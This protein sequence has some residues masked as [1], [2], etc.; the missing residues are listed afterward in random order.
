MCIRDRFTFDV[1][2][3]NSHVTLTDAAAPYVTTP[4]LQAGQYTIDEINM[5]TGWSLANVSCVKQTS[6]PLTN[7]PVDH[8]ATITVADGDAWVCTFTNVKQGTIQI[9]KVAPGAGATVFT[10]D[11]SWSGDHVMLTDGQ[12]TTPVAL[13]AGNYNISEINVP[14]GW[15]Q[16]NAT[17]VNGAATA[18]PLSLIHI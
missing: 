12:S 10:F 1:S 14:P 8:D 9:T 16:S 7:V 15:T 2:W 18:Q 11:V 6:A 13:A 3:S 4:P 17:C 5:P